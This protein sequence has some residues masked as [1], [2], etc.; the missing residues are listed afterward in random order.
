MRLSRY[1]L[2]QCNKRRVIVLQRGTC[3]SY[4]ILLVLA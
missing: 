2:R 1:G 3:Q 4:R